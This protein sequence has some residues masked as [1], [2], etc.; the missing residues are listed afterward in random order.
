M[1]LPSGLVAPP[2]SMGLRDSG[3][4]DAGDLAPSARR[5]SRPSCFPAFVVLRGPWA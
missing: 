5:T 3:R 4:P 1:N 2:L